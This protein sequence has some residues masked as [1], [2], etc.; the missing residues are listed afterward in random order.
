MSD[1]LHAGIDGVRAQGGAGRIRLQLGGKPKVRPGPAERRLDRFPGGMC[2]RPRPA[3]I[4]PLA[5]ETFDL[6]DLGGPSGHDG[7]QLWI[8]RYDGPQA[9]VGRTL[10]NP[11]T[12]VGSVL[13]IGLHESE[14]ELARPEPVHVV[15]RAA[16]RLG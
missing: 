9:G 11:S 8:E 16:G 6:A 13:H 14:V 2:A 7:N 10:P 5:L 12:L 3:D 1:D 4:D 15:H